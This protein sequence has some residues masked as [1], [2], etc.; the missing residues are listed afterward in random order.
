[1]ILTHNGGIAAVGT[2]FD[3]SVTEAERAVIIE[4]EDRL[5][6]WRRSLPKRR[7]RADQQHGPCSIINCTGLGWTWES[8]CG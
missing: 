2:E 8:N 1:M 5:A 3:D 7:P 6:A 4:R